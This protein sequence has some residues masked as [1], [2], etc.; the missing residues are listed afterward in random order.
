[1]A[2]WP[3]V[4]AYKSRNNISGTVSCDCHFR[5]CIFYCCLLCFISSKKQKRERLFLMPMCF[6]KRRVFMLGQKK[7]NFCHSALPKS[8]RTS[9]L[10]KQDCFIRFRTRLP[11]ICCHWKW[12][13][14]Y[15]LVKQDKDGPLL[16]Y[17]FKGR[18]ETAVHLFGAISR[19]YCRSVVCS[20]NTW[21]IIAK[22]AEMIR[23]RDDKCLV[24]FFFIYDKIGGKRRI[25]M[26]T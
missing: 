3:Y 18:D 26:V 23:E 6:T 19:S 15:V 10:W 14:P 21:P 1:M 20:A 2:E 8:Q 12:I 7:W 11:E 13:H 17:L 9:S 5:N 4:A 25:R 24:L 16:F 22:F